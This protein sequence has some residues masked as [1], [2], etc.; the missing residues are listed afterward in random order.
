M[1]SLLEKV[2]DPHI[3]CLSNLYTKTK[4]LELRE[5]IVTMNE[6][7][8]F[9]YSANVTKFKEINIYLSNFSML[10]INKHSHIFTII[11]HYIYGSINDKKVING[12][13]ID[14][15]YP[16]TGLL[17]LF[18]NASVED[19]P[20]VVVRA[21]SVILNILYWY[22]QCNTETDSE[23]LPFCAVTK[24]TLEILQNPIELFLKTNPMLHKNN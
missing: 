12:M 17:Q 5:K 24:F 18:K 20:S 8:A 4:H 14:S 7:K 22:G 13:F 23:I 11:D 16:E 15:E 1:K 19:K 2:A 6:I 3:I 9:A 21:I 10:D